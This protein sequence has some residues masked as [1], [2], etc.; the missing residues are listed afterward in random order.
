MAITVITRVLMLEGAP[1]ILRGDLAA[2]Y[3]LEEVAGKSVFDLVTEFGA[4]RGYRTISQMLFSFSH[5]A[6]VMDEDL[7]P[8]REFKAWLKAQPPV[9][10]EEFRNTADVVFG[11]LLDALNG[12][13]KNVSTP[14]GEPAQEVTAPA[15]PPPNPSTGTGSTTAP[16][17]SG[18]APGATSGA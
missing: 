7:D 12:G 6:R 17:P 18:G 1:V 14:A 11:L 10:V 13:R 9:Q 8:V 16:Q 2:I 4:K 3:V 5:G 15:P